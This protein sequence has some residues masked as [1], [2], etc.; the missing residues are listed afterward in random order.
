MSTHSLKIREK[1]EP[2]DGSPAAPPCAVLVDLIRL[3]AGPKWRPKAILLP[4]AE[5][6]RRKIYESC[7]DMDI[8]FDG[9][10]WAVVFDRALLVR[11]LK[12]VKHPL[13]SSDD[14]LAPLQP[15]PPPNDFLGSVR[16]AI[17]SSLRRTILT[18]PSR[19]KWLE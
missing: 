16:Q 15:S 5:I 4:A 18:S 6:V 17:R 12:Y 2:T 7:F 1:R 8:I 19:R 11:P 14:Q 13:R 9:N 10:V 3:A